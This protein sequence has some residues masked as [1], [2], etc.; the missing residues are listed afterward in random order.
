MLATMAAC[1]AR[2]DVGGSDDLQA[3]IASERADVLAHDRSREPSAWA[4]AEIRLAGGLTSLG[5]RGDESALREAAAALRSAMEVFT[6]DS[7]PEAWMQVQGSLGYVLSQIGQRGDDQA[8]RDAVAAD[9]AWLPVYGP[10]PRATPLPRH[11]NWLLAE[12]R[13]ADALFELGQRGDD[14]SLSEALKIYRAVADEDVQ[15]TGLGASSTRGRL[16]L[17][18]GERG[19]PRALHE[20]VRAFH[21]EIHDWP[22]RSYHLAESLQLLGDALHA[23]G[24]QGD[25]KARRDAVVAYNAALELVPRDRDPR[26]W[27]EFEYHLADALL[28]LGDHGDG[29]SLT[30]AVAAYHSALEVLPPDQTDTAR[31]TAGLARATAALAH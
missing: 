27:G 8:L 4:R 11:I 5:S 18:E 6:A 3:S 14:A 22:E 26:L 7:D 15:Q 25:A 10:Q 20:A 16:L 2:A 17:I 9:R 1:A 24:K 19:D 31:A 23:L 12:I 13:L 30:D 29:A 28:D 21:A